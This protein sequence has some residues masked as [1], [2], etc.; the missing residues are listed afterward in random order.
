MS[1]EACLRQHK[2]AWDAAVQHSFL[3]SCQQDTINR[4]QFD[5]W[6]VQDYLFVR[7]FTRLAANL[8][9]VAPYCD[10]EVLFG[11]LEA[12]RD[13]LKWFQV[14]HPLLVHRNSTPST[15]VGFRRNKLPS[16]V[17]ALMLICNR[18]TGISALTCVMSESSHMLFK[19]LCFGA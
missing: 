13:E 7:E 19:Q 4:S 3:K 6:L 11:G 12:L 10:Y 17:S 15:C 5:T 18:Q 8:L 16:A 2:D 9:T 14:R 1:C